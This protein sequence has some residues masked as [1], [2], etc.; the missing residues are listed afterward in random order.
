VLALL[1]LAPTI[2]EL[3]TGSTS[4]TPLV[5]DPPAF[6]ISLLGIIGLYGTGALLIREFVAFFHKGWASVLLLGAAYGI[7]E[8]GFAVHTF[9]ETSGPPVG[10]LGSYGHLFGVNWL[11]ALGLTVFHATYSIALPILLTYLWYPESKGV[12]WLD[13][14]LVAV[15]AGV[16]LFVVVLFSL[17]VGHGPSPASLAFFLGVVA[18]LLVLAYRV[19]AN[20]LAVRPGPRRVGRLGLVLA[21]TL[22]FDA[23]LA[24]LILSGTRAVPA[25]AAAAFVVGV[26]LVALAVVLRRAGTED[27]ARAEFHFA[28]GMLAILFVFDALL[29]FSDPGVFAVVALFAYLLYRLGRTLDRRS[30]VAPPLGATG[31]SPP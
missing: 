29:T 3:L 19:P 28:V 17:V 15:A 22:E 23:W 16:Y 20:A 26:N 12:R 27:L 31:S 14:G 24:V 5:T 4:V 11:W 1:L 25:Y 10:A 7:A 18:V 8:E 30:P 9:F 2:P 21:G 13:R 6:L